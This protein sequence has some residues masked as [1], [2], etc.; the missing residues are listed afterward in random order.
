MQAESVTNPYGDNCL[1]KVNPKRLFTQTPHH[2]E[3]YV[4]RFDFHCLEFAVSSQLPTCR[5]HLIQICF[6]IKTLPPVLLQIQI[7]V[8]IKKA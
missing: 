6:D 8:K 5:T 4:V 3:L 7:L 2:A 1:C